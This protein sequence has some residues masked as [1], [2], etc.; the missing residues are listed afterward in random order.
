MSSLVRAVA[1]GPFLAHAAAAERHLGT[2]LKDFA[3]LV[4]DLKIT[5]DDQRA[6]R[7]EGDL[8]V[9]FVIV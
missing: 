2:A 6:M 1:I 8:G 5:S 3:V 4:G 9:V 7:A